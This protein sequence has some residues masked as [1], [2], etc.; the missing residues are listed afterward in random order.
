MIENG[1]MMDRVVNALLCYLISIITK[2]I[3][4][5]SNVTRFGKKNFKTFF[6]V[7]DF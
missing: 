4:A 6:E 1:L 7:Q 5:L 2:L 3:G